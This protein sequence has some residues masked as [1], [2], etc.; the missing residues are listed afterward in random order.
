MICVLHKRRTLRPRPVQGTRNSRGF[1]LIE[2][3]VVVAIGLVL[4]A[5][6]I[7]IIQRSLNYFKFRSAVS[8]VT[9]AIQSARYQAIFHGC[10]YQ[11]VFNA[12]NLTYQLSG[13]T[14]LAPPALGC[15][16][17]FAPVTVAPIPIAASGV[18]LGAN[19]TLQFSP[20]GAVTP[21]P[22]TITLTSGPNTA[23]IQVFSYGRLNVTLTP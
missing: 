10:S 13:E 3:V 8:S 7:P 18:T 2:L 5:I 17:V 14:A 9:G 1:T 6:A 15:S 19:T 22:T 4:G 16:A 21:V 20:G 23:T 11:V 12:A